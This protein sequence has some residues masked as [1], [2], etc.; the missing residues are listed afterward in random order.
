MVRDMVTPREA[1]LLRQI[2]AALRQ[3]P[4]SWWL[5]THGSAFGRAGIPDILGCVHGRLVAIEVKRQG[6]KPTRLQEYEIARLSRAG[7]LVAVVHSVAEALRVSRFAVDEPRDT[8]E[9]GW[10]PRRSR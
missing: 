1:A 8:L 5:K 6:Q 3:I 2:L 9:N 7:A 10:K 4:G